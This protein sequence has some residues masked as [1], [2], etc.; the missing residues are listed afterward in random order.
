MAS[1][2]AFQEYLY[3][4]QGIAWPRTVVDVLDYLHMR[5][6]EPCA[7][8]VPQVFLQSLGWFERTAAIPSGE[9]L[10]CMEVVRQTVAYVVEL[11][12]VG[13]PPL[14][15]APR[16]SVSLLASLELF[17]VNPN[18]PPGLRIKAFSI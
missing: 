1:F 17:V 8:S 7:V 5:S 9:R 11:V 14:K 15:Q 13:G 12:S 3:L 16:P 2:G 4:A 18:Y 6:T 10:S